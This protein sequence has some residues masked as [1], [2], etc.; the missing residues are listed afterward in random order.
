MI[1][2]HTSNLC[3]RV[4]TFPCGSHFDHS[5]SLLLNLWYKDFQPSWKANADSYCSFINFIT[6]LWIIKPVWW[7]IVYQNNWTD[8]VITII[9]KSYCLKGVCYLKVLLESY[10]SFPLNELLLLFL[11]RS[12][13]FFAT[14][15]DVG[16]LSAIRLSQVRFV[17]PVPVV[18]NTRPEEARYPTHRL[19]DS[20]DLCYVYTQ[21]LYL[22]LLISQHLCTLS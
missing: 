9:P 22:C 6:F 18:S 5:I 2:S 17:S 4:C 8:F 13:T 1:W 12:S 20:P 10:G 14:V 15:C 7:D 21:V 16:K 3:L 11:C 19:L